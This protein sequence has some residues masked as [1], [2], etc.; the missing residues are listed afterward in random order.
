MD[1]IA[2]HL[3]FGC[4]GMIIET[5]ADDEWNLVDGAQ[6]LYMNQL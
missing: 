4:M 3:G 5:D 6:D 2:T 1:R